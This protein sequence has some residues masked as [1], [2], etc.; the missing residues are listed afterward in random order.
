METAGRPLTRSILYGLSGGAL[1][2]LFILA[3]AQQSEAAP[4]AGGKGGSGAPVDLH[5]VRELAKGS[6]ERQKAEQA[7]RKTEEPKAEKPQE[8]PAPRHNV[9]VGGKGGSGQPVDLRKIMNKNKDKQPP[10]TQPK[11][12][13][14]KTEKPQEKPAPRHNIPVG[15]KGGSGQPVDLRKIMNKNK[16]KQPPQTQPKTQEPKTEKP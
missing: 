14:P 7:Q 16:D 15:G 12:Q 10:Q 8:K 9:P 2:V 4:A 5:K 13:E 1:S 11:T 3:A 6:G